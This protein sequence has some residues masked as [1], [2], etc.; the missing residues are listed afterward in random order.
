MSIYRI[1]SRSGPRIACFSQVSQDDLREKGSK[2]V[3]NRSN[4]REA[5]KTFRE[6]ESSQ[7]KTK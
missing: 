5:T 2:F 6:V 3:V 4:R 1:C 7:I